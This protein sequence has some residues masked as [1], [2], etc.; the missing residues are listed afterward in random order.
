ML[1]NYQPVISLLC[2]L[3]PASAALSPSCSLAT[4][5]VGL[6]LVMIPQ[7]MQEGDED[8]PWGTLTLS[9]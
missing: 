4:G 2:P 9:G 3:S 5:A 6:V 1:S 8:E 7:R